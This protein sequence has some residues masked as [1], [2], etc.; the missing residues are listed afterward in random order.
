MKRP[1]GF[2]GRGAASAAA[3]RGVPWHPPPEYLAPPGTGLF[4]IHAASLIGKPLPFLRPA[5]MLS[6][7]VA[8]ESL[9]GTGSA[10]KAAV[11][12]PGTNTSAASAG[13]AAGA[14]AA[15]EVPVPVVHAAAPAAPKAR[16]PSVKGGV[17]LRLLIDEGVLQPGH[18]VLSV[19][20]APAVCAS[21]PRPPYAAAQPISRSYPCGLPLLQEYKGMQQLGT[22]ES[23]GRISSSIGGQQMVF[24]SP[25]AFRWADGRCPN[26]L[27]A[28]AY[29]Y[30][31]LA[32]SLAYVHGVSSPPSSSRSPLASKLHR[33]L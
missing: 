1:R 2:R 21:Y 26:P 13:A 17:T 20:S 30:C 27:G 11:V 23:D 10:M 12:A 22:L 24:E 4:N 33:S 31:V 6:Q 14:A 19:V 8:S 3:A 5:T 7:P 15:A 29:Y 16:K 9:D 32:N 28:P 18:D 25:S